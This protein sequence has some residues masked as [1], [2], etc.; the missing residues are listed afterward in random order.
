MT[1]I[2]AFYCADGVV[3]A[4]DSMITPAIGEIAVGH[5]HGRKIEILSGP[6]LFAFAGD[7]GQSARFKYLADRHHA[8]IPGTCHAIDF[9]LTITREI[10]E[11]FASTGIDLSRIDVSTVLSYAHDG[12]HH[13]CVFEGPLQPRLL[14]RNHFYVAL[15]SGKLSA[16]PF[17]RFLVDVFCTEGMPRLSD[18][19][20]LAVW[21]VQHVIDTNSGGVAPP[22][23]V[24]I[25]H[26]DES[27]QYVAREL[28]DEDIGEHQLAREGAVAAL[29]ERRREL[30]GDVGRQMVIADKPSLNP[31]ANKKPSD[32]T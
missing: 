31:E 3:V 11:Q 14:D 27:G 22:I 29:R 4:A 10:I 9:P 7:H 12:H 13:C 6:Q 26:A 19:T 18:A 17:L 1:V 24:A 15:G 20:F 30:H 28:P 23:R 8:L 25:F 2:V 32:E 5:H 21:T 16:D